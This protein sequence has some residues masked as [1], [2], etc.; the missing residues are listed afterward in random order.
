MKLIPLEQ[1]FY[2]KNYSKPSFIFHRSKPDN[3]YLFAIHQLIAKGYQIN[4]ELLAFY[5]KRASLTYNYEEL[6]VYDFNKDSCKICLC[7]H[8]KKEFRDF[9]K[10]N[11][12]PLNYSLLWSDQS[13][14][15]ALSKDHYLEL[16]E[17]NDSLPKSKKFWFEY[18]NLD[19]P[20]IKF[21]FENFSE[22]TSIHIKKGCWNHADNKDA[23]F[24]ISNSSDYRF[25]IKQY[26]FQNLK[27]LTYTLNKDNQ[28]IKTNEYPL[29]DSLLHDFEYNNDYKVN[30]DNTLESKEIEAIMNFSEYDHLL[31][32]KG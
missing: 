19:H 30:Y 11:N 26:D 24:H 15:C 7:N 3:L 6:Q 28:L 1:S 18:I 10:E 2:S 20:L 29:I 5:L 23:R 32:L 12:Y 9:C 25:A 14:Y 22:E 27:T 16:K 13:I 21:L 31:I 17:K 4:E 8:I